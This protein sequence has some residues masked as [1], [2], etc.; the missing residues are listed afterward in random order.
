MPYNIYWCYKECLCFVCVWLQII[1][2]NQSLL[3][4]FDLQFQ[5]I[6]RQIKYI[7]VYKIEDVCLLIKFGPKFYGY[8]KIHK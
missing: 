6:Y 7:S 2:I 3:F 1:A 8:Q 4:L 5:F